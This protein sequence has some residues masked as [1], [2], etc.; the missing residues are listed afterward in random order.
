LSYGRAGRFVLPAFLTHF[1]RANRIAF[2]LYSHFSPGSL[3]TAVRPFDVVLSPKYNGM[4]DKSRR[5]NEA[6]KNVH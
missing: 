4:A 2:E 1:R 5:G 6:S 3:M